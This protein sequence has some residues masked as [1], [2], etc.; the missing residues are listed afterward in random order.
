LVLS[1]YPAPFP[2]NS[3]PDRK[4]PLGIYPLQKYPLGKY[5]EQKILPSSEFALENLPLGKYPLMEDTSSLKG[6]YSK[7][8]FPTGNSPDNSFSRQETSLQKI[9]VYFP[10]TNT[11]YM[12]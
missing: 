1:V 10:I 2:K 4:Y 7:K 3:L 12:H 5:L 11:I 6:N 8:I 9:Y